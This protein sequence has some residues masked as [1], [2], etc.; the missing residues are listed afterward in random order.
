MNRFTKELCSLK[1]ALRSVKRKWKRSSCKKQICVPLISFS[2]MEHIVGIYDP[3][4][5]TRRKEAMRFINW[6]TMVIILCFT[7]NPYICK[8]S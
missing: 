3:I 1:E 8:K 7:V 4:P 2:L 6:K 5:E